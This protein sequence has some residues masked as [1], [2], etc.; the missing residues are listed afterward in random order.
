MSL[1]IEEIDAIQRNLE[2]LVIERTQELRAREADLQAQNMRFDAAVSNMSQGLVMFDGDARLVICN[3]R[4]IDMYHLEADAIRPGLSLR[5]L[6]DRRIANGT[7]SGDPDQYIEELLATIKA[8]TPTSQFVELD[9]G[10]T[11]ALVNVPMAGG[12]WVATHEDITERRRSE[13]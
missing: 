13:M 7:F 8:G 1:M 3:H 4:Y 5:Q 12:G 10:R 11:V 2:Q 9:D 6:I